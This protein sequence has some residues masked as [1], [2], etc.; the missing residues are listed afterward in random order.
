MTRYSGKEVCRRV[1]RAGELVAASEQLGQRRT[2]SPGC[3]GCQDHY[4]WL[5]MLRLMVA[6]DDAMV[7]WTV[8]CCRSSGFPLLACLSPCFILPAWRIHMGV[9]AMGSLRDLCPGCLHRL[10]RWLWGHHRIIAGAAKPAFPS[11]LAMLE[12]CRHPNRPVVAVTCSRT[13]S[14]RAPSKCTYLRKRRWSWRIHSSLGSASWWRH[15]RARSS[16]AFPYKGTGHHL[17]WS[18]LN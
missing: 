17:S 10:M 13:C 5:A 9:L 7:A 1:C 6:C 11:S 18:M 8:G 12:R 4:Q 16:N 2:R 14:S 15:M 3:H